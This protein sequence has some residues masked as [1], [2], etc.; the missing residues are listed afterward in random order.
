MAAFVAEP[1]LSWVNAQLLPPAW[2]GDE[3]SYSPGICLHAFD[4][5]SS[6]VARLFSYLHTYTDTNL[7]N[8]AH[9]K[10]PCP[11]RTPPAP[12]RQDT[13]PLP[14]R[15]YYLHFCN[16]QDQQP[17]SS[18]KAL[19]HLGLLCFLTTLLTPRHLRALAGGSVVRLSESSQNH[20]QGHHNI[21]PVEEPSQDS[22][23]CWRFSWIFSTSV[24]TASVSLGLVERNQ[25][26]SYLEYSE[27]PCRRRYISLLHSRQK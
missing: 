14:P 11:S 5:S 24:M 15:H 16:Q 25:A 3:S 18:W 21:P 12:A 13:T 7:T 17:S 20:V 9:P 6:S 4:S 22:S 23:G 27:V 10:Y 26:W 8:H 2:Q 1:Q 19:H